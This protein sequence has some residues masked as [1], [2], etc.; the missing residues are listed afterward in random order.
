MGVCGW[1]AHACIHACF[2]IEPNLCFGEKVFP[3]MQTVG[4][5]MVFAVHHHAIFPFLNEMKSPVN[6]SVVQNVHFGHNVN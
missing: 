4:P 6:M 3:S 1:L 2:P 5:A